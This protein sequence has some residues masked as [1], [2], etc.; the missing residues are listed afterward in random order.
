M[1]TGH[2]VCVLHNTAHAI[3]KGDLQFI[4]PKESNF[5]P[6]FLHLVMASVFFRPPRIVCIEKPSHICN[7]LKFSC[8]RCYSQISFIESRANRVCMRMNSARNTNFVENRPNRICLRR[9]GVPNAE[10]SANTHKEL[11]SAA[12]GTASSFSG[13]QLF[14]R[15]I[16]SSS[17]FHYLQTT[18]VKKMS[19]CLK[20]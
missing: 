5:K 12:R 11:N 20:N 15:R 18:K 13:L 14:Y 3:C 8:I 6:K 19:W 16:P 4:H 9:N 2:V 10:G 7:L 1:P 17:L